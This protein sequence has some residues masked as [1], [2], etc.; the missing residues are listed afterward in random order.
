MRYFVKHYT[1]EWLY[2]AVSKELRKRIEV[3][4]FKNRLHLDRVT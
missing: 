3:K 2:K 1:D 4:E